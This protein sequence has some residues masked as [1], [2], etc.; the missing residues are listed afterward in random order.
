ML[1]LPNVGQLVRVGLELG[2][3]GPYSAGKTNLEIRP[4]KKGMCSTC[5]PVSSCFGVG[6]LLRVCSYGFCS[7]TDAWHVGSVLK[8][9]PQYHRPVVRP[10]TV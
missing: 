6:H 10:D 4:R 5:S 3:L 2:L 1:D 9:A 7:E 8:T